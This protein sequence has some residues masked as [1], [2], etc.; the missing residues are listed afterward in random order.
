MAD[1]PKKQKKNDLADP[2]GYNYLKVSSAQDCTGLIPTAVA[3]EEE[4]ENY[5]ALYP[6]LPIP[7]TELK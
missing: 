1:D 3:K 4:I 2:F 5:V 6:F 7:P